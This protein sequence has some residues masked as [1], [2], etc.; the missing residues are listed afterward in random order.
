MDKENS[1]CGDCAFN[2][3]TCAEGFMPEGDTCK[4]YD[5]AT[6]YPAYIDKLAIVAYDAYCAE[7]GG[8]NFKGEPLPTGKEFFA[9][10]SKEKQANGWR[11]AAM[12][13]QSAILHAWCEHM[14]KQEYLSE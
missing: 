8:V 1:I 3:G 12:S 7:V 13:L 6:K 11:A 14:K 4:G 5:K 2:V 10:P 9:D